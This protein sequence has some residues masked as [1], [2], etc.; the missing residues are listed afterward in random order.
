MIGTVWA[1]EPL[2]A[3]PVAIDVDHRGRLFVCETFRQQHG[4]E[5]N[6]YHMDW[7]RD[8]LAAESVADRAAY[9]KKFYPEDWEETFAT[10]RDRIR[11]VTDTDGDGTADTATVFADGF[12]D[13]LDGTGAGVLAR[14]DGDVFYTCIPDLYR[15]RDDDGD[16]M[17]D[18]V[19]SLAT[20]FGVRVAFRGHDM[21]GLTMGP[22]GRLYWTIGDRGF[23]VVT[24]EGTTLAMP[25]TGAV[26]RSETDGTGL[27]VFA[28]G[29]RNP[30][31]LAFDDAGNLFTWD[32]NSDS[33]D[34]ARWV[35][36]LRHADSGWRMYFQ[37]LPDRGPWNR[38]LMWVPADWT[39]GD[40]TA[41]PEA[42]TDPAT[43]AGVPKNVAAAA[44][45]PAYVFPR[46]RTS[47]TGR[48]A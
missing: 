42:D 15:L 12:G 36:V 34:L 19:D 47:A 17:A 20:G 31:E 24:K 37:Y 2:L 45:R 22:D 5:D 21:H 3:N 40:G 32:N 9:M 11:L 30:Q 46:W 1:A 6:R 8:D 27:E 23:H 4:V 18:E 33:G 39:P 7:L 26:F 38:E 10:E 29:L 35:H 44:V 43:A 14:P 41:D 28:Y 13:L 25:D 16:G 48:A